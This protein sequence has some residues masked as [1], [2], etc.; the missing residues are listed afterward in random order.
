MKK[1]N[2]LFISTTIIILLISL[3]FY[4]KNIRG[5]KKWLPIEKIG[6]LWSIIPLLLFSC[7]S[8]KLAIYL[9]PI[10]PGNIIILINFSIFEKLSRGSPIPMT[11]ILL[12]SEFSLSKR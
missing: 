3:I 9:L 4:L 1:K 7:A 2:L 10:F 12:I 6:F 5:Y 11:T 8:G